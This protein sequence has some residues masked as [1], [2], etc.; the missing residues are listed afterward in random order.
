MNNEQATGGGS[1]YWT[2]RRTCITY[3][4]I[5]FDHTYNFTEHRL[6]I[7]ALEALMDSYIRNKKPSYQLIRQV[8]QK[9]W[10]C[11]DLDS[12]A[13]LL[14]CSV[15]TAYTNNSKAEKRS[16]DDCCVKEITAYITD[17]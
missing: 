9:L 8:M 6:Y 10:I 16:G 1:L 12:Q 11:T 13:V 3:L 2:F 15:D 14:L 4:T 5:N 7:F 17:I